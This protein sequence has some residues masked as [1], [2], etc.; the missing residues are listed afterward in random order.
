MKRFLLNRH[1]DVSGTS[2]T[3]IVAEGVLLSNGKCVIQWLGQFS[4]LVVWDNIES[5]LYVNGHGGNTTID[6]IDK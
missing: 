2:G 1:F 4:S 3:G 6:W 5:C